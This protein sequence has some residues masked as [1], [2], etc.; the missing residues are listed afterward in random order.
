LFPYLSSLFQVKIEAQKGSKLK[1][2]FG[3]FEM[4][5][6]GDPG[7]DKVELEFF[8]KG[9]HDHNE[10][11]KAQ[12]GVAPHVRVRVAKEV[13][14]LKRPREMHK[15]ELQVSPQSEVTLRQ[16]QRCSQTARKRLNSTFF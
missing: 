11:F 15:K 7:A 3:S 5:A 6:V 4:E 9:A 13:D 2:K 14:N 16:V 8:T 10:V 1:G 12:K